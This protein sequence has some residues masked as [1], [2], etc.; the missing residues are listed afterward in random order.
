MYVPIEFKEAAVDA[1]FIEAL[2]KTSADAEQ[3]LEDCGRLRL[4]RAVAAAVE[5]FQKQGGSK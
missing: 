2:V 3:I 1:A 5:L 4:Q